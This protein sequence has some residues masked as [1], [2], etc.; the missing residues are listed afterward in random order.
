MTAHLDQPAIRH[1][2]PELEAIVADLGQ[3]G[4]GRSG[5]GGVSRIDVGDRRADGQ[6]VGVSEQRRRSDERLTAEQLGQPHGVDAAA[7]MRFAYSMRSGPLSRSVLNKTP[8]LGVTIESISSP[9]GGEEVARTDDT[10]AVSAGRECL[11]ECD[12]G[13]PAGAVPGCDNSWVDEFDQVS[14]GGGY[15]ILHQA[16][17]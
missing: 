10:G 5:G 1:A 6:H 4:G 9:R 3:G 2:E 7:S 13:T 14:H 11:G 8:S 12:F 15:A 16:T 17:G